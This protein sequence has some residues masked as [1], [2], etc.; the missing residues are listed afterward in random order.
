MRQRVYIETTI[1]SFYYEVRSEPEM[2]ARRDWTRDWWDNHRDRFD[3]V[4]SAPVIDELEEGSHP[5]KSEVLTLIG[6]LPILP[7]ESTIGEIVD[8]YIDNYVMPKDPRGDALHLALASY[9]R[10][11]FLLTWNCEHLANANKFEHIR[12]INTLLGLY[13]PIL[14]TPLELLTSSEIAP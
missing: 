5:K 13:V 7:I 12:H 6:G 2:V 10:C 9:H 14:I 1:P 11:Q 8:A 4:T 3:A